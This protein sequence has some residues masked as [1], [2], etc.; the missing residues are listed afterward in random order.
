MFLQ[1]IPRCPY[2]SYLKQNPPNEVRQKNSQSKSI[3][4]NPLY[5]LDPRLIRNPNKLALICR[6]VSQYSPRPKYLRGYNARFVTRFVYDVDIKIFKH[7]HGQRM[8]DNRK[9][10]SQLREKISERYINTIRIDELERVR[11]F[12]DKFTCNFSCDFLKWLFIACTNKANK[13]YLIYKQECF[14]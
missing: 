9:H 6:S 7:G 8:T 12:E 4:L 2:L 5:F 14:I 11:V 10:Y 3:I 13:Y 1:K